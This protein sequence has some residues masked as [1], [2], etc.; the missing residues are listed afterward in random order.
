MTCHATYLTTATDVYAGYVTNV[1][2]VTGDPPTG[3]PL[4]D[5]DEETVTLLALPVV[6]VTG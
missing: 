2:T 6:P 4:T 5:R 3:P 1:A